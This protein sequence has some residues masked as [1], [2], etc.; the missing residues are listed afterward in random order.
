MG[1]MSFVA[2]FLGFGIGV[3]FRLKALL[4]VL[5]LLLTVTIISAFI[6]G[7]SFIEAALAVIEVQCIAQA[8]YFSGLLF[9][10]L[11]DTTR[12]TRPIL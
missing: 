4:P 9:R 11:I 12:R 5:A 6:G 7:V 1:Y 8:A 10:S 3:A 2:A